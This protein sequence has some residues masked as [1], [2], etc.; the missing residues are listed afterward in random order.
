MSNRRHFL[1][2]ALMAAAGGSLGLAANLRAEPTLPAGLVYTRENP[3]K[4]AGKDGSHLPQVTVEGNS[5]TLKTDHIMTEKHFIVRHTVVAAD[6]TV[7]GEKTFMPADEDAVSVFTLPEG[8][9]GTLYAT[10]FCNKHDLWVTE[11]SV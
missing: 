5:V 11:F 9:S 3:G 7:L 6:G 10:S 8:T 2:T 4:W 1:K